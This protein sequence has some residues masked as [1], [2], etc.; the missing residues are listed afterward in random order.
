MTFEQFNLSPVLVRAV[1]EHGYTTPTPVQRDAIPLALAGRDLIASAQTGT[2]KTAAFL[3][4]AL[5]RLQNP[6]AGPAQHTARPG[7]D[8]D[9]RARPTRS[10]PRARPMRAMPA[11]SRAAS[12]AACPTGLNCSCSAS[13]S[14]FWS[15]RPAG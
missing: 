7:P 6:E 1:A 5:E 2:G 15:P 4:P 12:S 3:L 9:S 14:T 8:P 10:W 11:C 13:A